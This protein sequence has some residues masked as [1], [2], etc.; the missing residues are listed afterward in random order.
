MFMLSFPLI[1][2]KKHKWSASFVKD[3]EYLHARVFPGN[4]TAERVKPTQSP[5]VPTLTKCHQCGPYSQ[6]PILKLP[7]TPS[8]Y[9]HPRFIYIYMCVLTLTWKQLNES[10]KKNTH[11]LNFSLWKSV[12]TTEERRKTETVTRLEL[13]VNGA[14]DRKHAAYRWCYLQHLLRWSYECI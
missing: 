4:H 1:Q 11:H 8:H 12:M 3:F 9:N 14:L 2:Q 7:H 6:L 5:A 10:S 13:L